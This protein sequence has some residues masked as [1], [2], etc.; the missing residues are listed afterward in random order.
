MIP[1]PNL[2]EHHIK[3]LEVAADS[4][5]KVLDENRQLYNQVQDLKGE[6]FF[7]FK[8][9]IFS[10]LNLPLLPEVKGFSFFLFCSYQG[11]L[12]FFVESGLFCLNNLIDSPV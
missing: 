4:Y 11:A 6:L 3:G 8:K 5:H 10:S 12:E 2:S 1:L 9:I 7:F